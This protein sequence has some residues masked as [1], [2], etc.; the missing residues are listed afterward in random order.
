MSNL[1]TGNLS[2]T[3]QS[4]REILERGDEHI[5]LYAMTVA[6]KEGTTVCLTDDFGN[7]IRANDREK[8]VDFLQ[9]HCDWVDPE[10]EAGVESARDVISNFIAKSEEA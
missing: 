2:Y 6:F 7:E 8:L 9:E 10:S 4:L 3:A 1:G 5:F